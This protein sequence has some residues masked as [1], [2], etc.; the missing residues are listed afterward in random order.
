MDESILVQEINSGYCL[1]EEIEGFIFG[2]HTL[3]ADYIEQVAL[4]HVFKNEVYKLFIFEAC[5][6][7]NYV[8]MLQFLLDLDLS[9]ERLLHL[10]R[11]DCRLVKLLHG[12]LH[13]GWQVCRELHGAV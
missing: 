8:Y 4:F 9:V 13:F 7:S 11:L 1:N 5:E 2:Q 6:K 10:G 3:L 12:Y